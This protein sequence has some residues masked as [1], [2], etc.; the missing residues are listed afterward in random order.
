MPTAKKIAA[1]AELTEALQRS[2]LTIV[3]DY[4]GLTVADL[5]NLRGQLHVLLMSA[6]SPRKTTRENS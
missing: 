2:K 1:V 5:Q 4:R 3:T 6:K